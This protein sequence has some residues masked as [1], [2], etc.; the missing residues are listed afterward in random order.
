VLFRSAEAQAQVSQAE[1]AVAEAEDGVAG[2]TLKAPR[3][4]TITAVNG[5]LGG[6]ASGNSSTGDNS[7]GAAGSDQPDGFM[8]I[9]DLTK[10]EVAASVS[11]T[12]ATKLKAGQAGT[13][14]WN[15]LPGAETTGKLA[16]IDPNATSENNVVTY[17]VTFTL[18][19]LPDG[20]RV[21]QSVN[22]SVTVGQ[23]ENV[24]YVTSAAVTGAG[25][26]HTV[27]VLENGQRVARPVEIGLE[28]DGAT[29]IR[30]GL[31]A[32][33]QVVVTIPSTTSNQGGF[34]GPGGGFP[35]GG[36]P[37]GSRT[38]GTRTGGGR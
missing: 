24:V 21:G 7:S 4:G 22:V 34:T 3:A 25:N 20:V 6:Q 30:S 5:T 35:G 28:G 9:A 1:T 27:T 19:K 26:R 23:A 8:D 38:G 13:V 17:G 33:E 14:T 31:A 37:G 10:L 36:F 12:D 16:T 15:A 18:D 32:G 29:E 2:T 11:E